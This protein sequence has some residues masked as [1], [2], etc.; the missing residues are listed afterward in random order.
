MTHP[1]KNIES[2]LPVCPCALY[3]DGV[4]YTRTVSPGNVDSLINF[5]VHNLSTGRRHLVGAIAKRSL[6]RCGCRGRCTLFGI[7]QFIK[8][9]MESAA[10]GQRPE[11]MWDGTPWSVGDVYATKPKSLSCRFLLCEI[12]ADWAEMVGTFGLR[13]WN[14]VW[15]PCPFCKSSR[16]RLGECEH[17][18][19]RGH[20]WGVTGDRD[21]L[22]SC[23]SCEIRVLVSSE[24]V[25]AIIRDSGGLGF[26]SRRQ[27]Q[28][29]R[30]A[31]TINSKHMVSH[32]RQGSSFRRTSNLHTRHD[33]PP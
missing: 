2:D 26:D 28:G 12:R 8:W 19:A 13:A 4:R 15:R 10:R 5:T 14:S 31:K 33:H 16:E 24:R 21:Y 30:C 23:R 18:T 22:E 29:S 20:D 7:R 1:M 3:A 6:C 27:A 9:S 17:V 11:V 25:R 32:G